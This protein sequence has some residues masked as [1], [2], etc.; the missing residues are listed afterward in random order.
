MVVVED[1]PMKVKG[2]SY[3]PKSKLSSI[4]TGMPI[5]DFTVITIHTRS[6][7]NPEAEINELHNVLNMFTNP[8]HC[9][10]GNAI[11]MGDFNQVPNFVAANFQSALDLGP[12]YRQL[13]YSGSSTL[14]QALDRY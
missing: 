11:I 12:Q 1:L 14:T 3:K 6:R 10:S 4:T 5:F 8:P 7:L 13:Q 2:R 9:Y